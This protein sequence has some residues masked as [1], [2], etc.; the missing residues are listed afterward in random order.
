MDQG[1]RDDIREALYEAREKRLDELDELIAVGALEPA[2]TSAVKRY[3]R[4]V[5]VI[6]DFTDWEDAQMSCA[7][8]EL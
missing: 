6:R 1:L 3:A 2:L 8:I 7:P 5:I 4:S